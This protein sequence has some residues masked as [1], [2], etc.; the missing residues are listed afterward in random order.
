MAVQA[1]PSWAA[2]PSQSLI[3]RL[4]MITLAPFSISARAIISP[5]PRLPPVTTAV[6]PATL[7]RDSIFMWHWLR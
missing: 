2:R 5:M 3:L 7:N 6:L 4:V 1:G